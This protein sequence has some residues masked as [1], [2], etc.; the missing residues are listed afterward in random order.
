MDC[1]TAIDILK[2]S[3]PKTTRM[4]SGHLEGGFDNL[5]CELGQAI[6]FAINSL[7]RN[8]PEKADFEEDDLGN[9]CIL[10][11]NCLAF[12]GYEINNQIKYYPKNH[13][14]NYCPFCGQKLD[15]SEMND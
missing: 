6:T 2:K 12:I 14:V 3:Y 8:L 15:W 11:P 7:H 13:V 5:E 10:C 1:K 9:N 4:V